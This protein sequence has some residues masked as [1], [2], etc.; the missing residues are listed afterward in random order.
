MS[1]GYCLASVAHLSAPVVTVPQP[2]GAFFPIFTQ[3]GLFMFEP[4]LMR[5]RWHGP[6]GFFIQVAH[7]TSPAVSPLTCCCHLQV[8]EFPPLRVQRTRNGGWRMNNG[9]VVFRTLGTL[10]IL[11][12]HSLLC[13]MAR[14]QAWFPAEHVR[15]PAA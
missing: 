15:L 11:K 6:R 1:N 7:H 4:A 8:N 2:G 13:R 3:D 14:S 10:R 9:Y 12:H 5:W